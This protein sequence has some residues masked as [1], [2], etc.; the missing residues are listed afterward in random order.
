MNKPVLE[1]GNGAFGVR[2]KSLLAHAEG[3]TV[4]DLIA[5]PL[6][7]CRDFKNR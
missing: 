2:D 7:R 4:S 6:N 5:R 1:F 3:D